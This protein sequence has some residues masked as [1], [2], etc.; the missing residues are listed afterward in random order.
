MCH[1]LVNYFFRGSILSF[2]VKINN[3]KRIYVRNCVHSS[4]MIETLFGTS[5]YTSI[6]IR[7]KIEIPQVDKI[8]HVVFFKYCTNF[9]LL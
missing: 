7:Y 6:R 4:C 3:L 1:F 5:N 8:M 2:L 9:Q